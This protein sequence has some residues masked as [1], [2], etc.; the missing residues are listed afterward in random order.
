[1]NRIDKPVKDKPAQGNT[2][3]TNKPLLRRRDF[4]LILTSL[5]ALPSVKLFASENQKNAGQIN[6]KSWNDEPWKTLDAV[7]EHLFPAV[8]GAP[9]AR[10]LGVLNYMQTM[11]KTPDA[12]P[13][14]MT[15]INNG[16]G[17]LNDLSLQM[18]KQNF[19]KLDEHSRENILR[20]IETSDA[21]ER[22]LSYL[23]TQLL[24][25]LVS[26]PV[27]GSNPN[28]IGWQWLEHPPGYPLPGHDDMYFKLA[29]RVQRNNKA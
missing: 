24:E 20:K 1:M 17:W 7:F 5:A 27:Y 9:G 25:A 26:D 11:L 3:H 28:G 22:W 4:L 19:I 6:N 15:F 2:G 8:E 16:V 10:D 21:G 14:D 29:R 23:L 12:D 13:E 18:Y